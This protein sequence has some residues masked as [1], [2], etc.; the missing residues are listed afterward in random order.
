MLNS[1]NLLLVFLVYL[2]TFF[3][4][5]FF[6]GGR[7]GG[8]RGGWGGG[9]H[10]HLNEQENTLRH[11]LR[12]TIA[13]YFLIPAVVQDIR[14]FYNVIS[15]PCIRKR[16]RRDVKVSKADLGSF[17]TVRLPLEKQAA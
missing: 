14:H 9:G 13:F 11:F 12:R 5:S 15:W 10:D 6:R 17:I 7:A 16:Q 2:I 8:W 3:F 4:F 1:R